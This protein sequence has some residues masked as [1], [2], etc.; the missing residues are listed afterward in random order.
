[1]FDKF[2]QGACVVTLWNKSVWN[3]LP[4][5]P[6]CRHA[7]CFQLPVLRLDDLPFP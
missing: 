1:M 3:T 4:G 6:G 5:T 2:P 7:S